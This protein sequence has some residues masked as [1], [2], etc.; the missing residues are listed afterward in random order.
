MMWCF[1]KQGEPGIKKNFYRGRPHQV[2][3]SDSSGPENATPADPHQHSAAW[4]DPPPGIPLPGPWDGP[5][6]PWYGPVWVPI[7]VQPQPACPPLDPNVRHW[8]PRPQCGQ[9]VQPGPAKPQHA[10][11]PQSPGLHDEWQC[12]WHQPHV[13]AVRKEAASVPSQLHAEHW[14]RGPISCFPG[15]PPS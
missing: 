1:M 13:R 14:W 3:D 8:Q 2:C 7:H 6:L 12:G 4:A 5:W 11:P 10:Q 9:R 15:Q